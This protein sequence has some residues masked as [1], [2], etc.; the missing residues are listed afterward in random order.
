MVKKDMKNMAELED[1][2]HRCPVIRTREIAFPSFPALCA[3]STIRHL[4]SI[5]PGS[6]AMQGG[7]TTAKGT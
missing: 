3:P 6:D 4:L 7:G 2:I 5:Y 1:H